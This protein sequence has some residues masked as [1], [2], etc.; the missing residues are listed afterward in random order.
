[1]VCF[2]GLDE[3][4]FT[5]HFRQK[6]SD[7]VVMNEVIERIKNSDSPTFNYVTGFTSHDPHNEELI[8][9]QA[10]VNK[11]TINPYTLPLNNTSLKVVL[12]EDIIRNYFGFL[13]EV[14]DTI[15]KLFLS[16]EENGLRKNTIVILYGDHRYYD[17]PIDSLENF[18]NYN[19]VPFVISLPEKYKA[20]TKTA[21]FVNIAPT[22]LN[23]LE[24]EKYKKP[25]HF[26]GKSLF[27][28]DRPNN[29][30]SKCLGEIFYFD[31][32]VAVIGNANTNL[33]QKLYPQGSISEDLLSQYIETIK[34]AVEVSDEAIFE[35]KLYQPT[36]KST[37]N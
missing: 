3:L 14:D 12:E 16:L 4:Y 9:Y 13:R 33:Y 22:I 24:G 8:E 31:E 35:D 28:D 29:V 15:E 5:P 36:T 2:T 34:K 11:V 25:S 23:L 37:D 21:S 30:L 32:E 6:E 20:K 7:Q 27:E 26:I 1:M 10:T 19:E 18:L 17:F